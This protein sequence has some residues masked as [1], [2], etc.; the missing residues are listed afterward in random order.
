MSLFVWDFYKIS[1]KEKGKCNCH[2]D[3][4]ANQLSGRASS[5]LW[6]EGHEFELILDFLSPVTTCE[7]LL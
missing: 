3:M 5:T 4:F 1:W 6:A 7:Q 2:W